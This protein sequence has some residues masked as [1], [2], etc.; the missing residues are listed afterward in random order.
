ME[1]ILQ[2]VIVVWAVGVI[3]WR[4]IAAQDLEE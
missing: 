4:W 2:V 3:V 1:G